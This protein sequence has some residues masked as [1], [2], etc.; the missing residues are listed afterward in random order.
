[1]DTAL[2]EWTP[3]LKAACYA[4]LQ[5]RG[6]VCRQR[7]AR[8]FIQEQIDTNTHYRLWAMNTAS[9]VRQPYWHW[10]DTTAARRIARVRAG[11][12]C[13]EGHVRSAEFRVKVAKGFEVRLPR[14]EDR[15][16]RACY[17]CGPIQ[18]SC[19]D[20]YWADSVEHMLVKCTCPN[21]RTIRARVRQELSQLAQETGAGLDFDDDTTLLT[22]LLLTT[23][24]T[25]VGGLQRQPAA[26][27][28]APE[29]HRDS[30]QFA[31]RQQQARATSGWVAALTDPWI[32][33]QRDA[34]AYRRQHRRDGGDDLDDMPGG[35]L[36][37]IVGRA[38]QDMW[39]A[40]NRV[41]RARINPE[42]QLRARDPEPN[43]P[44]PTEAA[45]RRQARDERRKQAAKVKRERVAVERAKLPEAV[46]KRLARDRAKADKAV[47]AEVRR[48]Q[49][50][51][52]RAEALV[53]AAQEAHAAA[54]RRVD[55]AQ[56]I[57][58]E[59]V[60]MA[61]VGSGSGCTR[62]EWALLQRAAKTKRAETFEAGQD[63]A[64]AAGQLRK[65]LR[66]ADVAQRAVAVAASS[67]GG[68]GPPPVSPRPS[69][70]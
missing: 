10:L 28:A 6:N 7:L 31:Y 67:A 55:D 51:A 15:N 49:V 47:A 37:V 11:Q 39:M 5:R 16:R 63:L 50:S 22:A 48:L 46:A 61:A 32:H 12:A 8:A 57:E 65:L 38:V 56:Q 44:L 3:T 21:M 26:P 60:A 33:A 43:R 52:T 54:Q 42:Y 35:K 2:H 9:A 59:A 36:V 40:H 53:V 68:D 58:E 14:I 66:V 4:A 45:G 13:N 1:M 70:A 27:G 23:G 29:L 41:C 30:P 19:P 62:H 20:V 18:A 25:P 24:V 69:P 17:R 34:Y 64:R